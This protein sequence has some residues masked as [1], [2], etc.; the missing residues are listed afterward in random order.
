VQKLVFVPAEEL[1][2]AENV[3]LSY[4]LQV[5]TIFRASMALRTTALLSLLGATLAIRSH[6]QHARAVC[7]PTAGGT[8]STDDVPSILDA[9]SSCGNGGT[10]VFPAGTTYYLNTVLDLGDCSGCDIQIEGLLKFASDT[11]YWN[12]KTAMINAKDVD[13]LK[14]RSLTGSGVID[15]NGQNA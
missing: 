3:A 2:R 15:G 7:T 8:S 5:T 1:I 10:I 11:D 4:L 9:L 12:G 14:I 13:G 6:T